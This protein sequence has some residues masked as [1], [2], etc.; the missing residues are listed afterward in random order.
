MDWNIYILMFNNTSMTKSIYVEGDVL[1]EN[2]EIADIF[3][4]KSVGRM[5]TRNMPKDLGLVFK[6]DRVKPVSIH[7]GFVF[8]PL[9]VIWAENGEVVEV[10]KLQ[11]WT[12]WNKERAD[13]VIEVHPNKLEFVSVGDSIQVK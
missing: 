6:F 13:M 12:G 8:Y 2:A 7:M 5:F 1:C 11:P 4:E 9:G 3:L 10:R